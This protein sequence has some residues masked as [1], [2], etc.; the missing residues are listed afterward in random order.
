MGKPLLKIN[1]RR[2]NIKSKKKIAARRRFD[3]KSTDERL[4]KLR[5]GS[6]LEVRKC[7]GLK[8]YR[9]K[10]IHTKWTIIGYKPDQVPKPKG[11]PDVEK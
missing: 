6:P 10:H 3:D 1:K 4:N 5:K 7:R 8:A 11:E 2:D 9:L